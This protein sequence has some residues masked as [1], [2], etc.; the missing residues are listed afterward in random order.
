MGQEFDAEIR[1][2][3]IPAKDYAAS[4]MAA[5][6][7]RLLFPRVWQ[8]VG[9]VEEL[10][11]VGSYLLYEIND[12]SIIVTRSGPDSF[13]AFHNV[14]RHRGRQL[15]DAPRGRVSEGF[16][17]AF[18]GWR[19]DLDGNV[20][21][22]PDEAD[23]GNCPAFS[24]DQLSLKSVAVD[25]WAGWL[26]ITMASNPQ[27][28]LEWLA[29]L[30]EIIDPFELE[31]ARIY[32]HATIHAP[33]NWKVV[34][35]A[36]NEGYHSAATHFVGRFNYDTAYFPSET[37]GP[38]AMFRSEFRDLPKMR[39]ASG[40]WEKA[41]DL[42]ELLMISTQ[43]IRDTLKAQ[44]LDPG[45]AAAERVFAELPPE[46]PPE[47]VLLKNLEFHREELARRGVAWPE[48]LTLETIARAGVDWHIFPNSIFLPSADGA[49]WYTMRPNPR[50]PD[51]CI[52]DIWSLGR[53]APGEEP[54]VDHQVF[55]G[56]E[57]FKGNNPFLE[58]DFRNMLAV[59]KGMKSR[60][61]T[62]SRPN[63]IQEA[64]VS[65]F[66]Q[67]LRKYLQDDDIG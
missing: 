4:E 20:T 54:V 46:T 1:P 58:E 56:F 67:T 50:D 48:G 59:Q 12:E 19:Y 39:K 34:V 41:A 22:I 65:H 15:K 14:C 17:C 23:W 10:S 25:V 37:H 64:A 42:R 62:S 29:P 40:A 2:D 60:G 44:V 31:K 36:F 3:F 52:F 5:L 49:L 61:F 63:P 7:A 21:H 27:P 38:H 32:W 30:P 51:A 8:I 26:W 66:H 9:R 45:V 55:H 47:E 57:A 43:G 33:V 13:K 35:E 18:H 28:L 16:Y 24:R 6:E 11:D 53:F